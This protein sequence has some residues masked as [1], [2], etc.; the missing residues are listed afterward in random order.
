MPRR[1]RLGRNWLR[2]APPLVWA[3]SRSHKVILVFGLVV[4]VVFGIGL[5]LSWHRNNGE[6][7]AD[8]VRSMDGQDGV[9]FF[10]LDARSD[11]SKI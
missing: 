7:W 2:S 4:M 10:N 3:Y 11:L 8:I 1:S 5:Y 9:G 6:N